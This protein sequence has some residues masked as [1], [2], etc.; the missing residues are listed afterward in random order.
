MAGLLDGMVP[1]TNGGGFFDNIASNPLVYMGLGLASGHGWNQGAQNAF[2]G[3][4]QMRQAQLQAQQQAIQNY[5][6]LQGLKLRQDEFGLK[7]QE[8]DRPEVGFREG[9]NGAVPYERSRNGGAVTISPINNPGASNSGNPTGRDSPFG[10]PYEKMSVGDITK[11]NETGSKAQNVANFANQFEDR[12]AGYGIG[13]DAAMTYGRTMP[14][15]MTPKNW[16]DAAAFWQNYDRYKNVVRHEQYGGALTPVEVVQFDKADINPNMNPEMIRK[17][18]KIQSDIL[19]GSITRMTAALK[20]EGYRPEA[21][22]A[23]FGKSSAG[24]QQSQAG[25]DVYAKARAAIQAGAPPDAVKMRLKAGGY[26]PS[27]LGM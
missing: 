21:I 18:L 15:S 3:L 1:P 7:K 22:D 8:F 24:G 14:T 26:D 11:L 2:A 6:A 9:P 19:N 23:A 25:A 27:Q 17:N 5:I 12:F 13:G 20:A 4:Q 10:K 16:A